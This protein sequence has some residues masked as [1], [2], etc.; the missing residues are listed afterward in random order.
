VSFQELF[1][2]VVTTPS[3]IN[4][5]LMHLHR[6]VV[7][8]NMKSVIELGVRHG[9]STIALLHALDKTGGHLWSVDVAKQWNGLESDRWTFIE[10]D[11]LSD[12]VMMKLPLYAI[13]LVFID[14]YHGYQQTV[15]EITKYKP[16]VRSG[17]MMAFHDTNVHTFD[18][19]PPG[20][21]PP[22]PVRKAVEEML[23]DYPKVVFEHNNG[24]TEVTL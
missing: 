20:S 9:N 19:H 5:H 24:F 18:H 3:D 13:D 17:G 10:G 11:D 15:N 23:G 14:T 4:E 12:E 21:E 1:D 16:L 22:F 8:H 2:I 6:L 7:A